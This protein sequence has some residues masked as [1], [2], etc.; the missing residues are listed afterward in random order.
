MSSN[1]WHW[2]HP[3]WN[4]WTWPLWLQLGGAVI[5]LV[6]WAA[7]R[8]IHL[9]A[10]L[11][12]K[13]RLYRSKT[14]TVPLLEEGLPGV[15]IFKPL[16]PGSDSNLV[17][18][19]DT[20][21]NLDYPKYEIL[22]CIQDPS[23]TNLGFFVES[24]QE[25]YPLVETKVFYGGETIG[26]NPKINNMHPA[27]QASK[28]ELI[29]ISDSGIRMNEDTLTDMVAHMTNS[30]GLVHQMPYICDKSGIAASLEK[31]YFGTSH[32][33]AY[34]AANLLGINC[35]TGMSALMRKNL[36]VEAGGLKAFGS[37]LAED[38]FM[39]KAIMDQGYQIDI[40]SQP[41]QQNPG[42]SSIPNFHSRI[43][44]WTK[45]RYAMCPH[46]IVL[47]PLTE[48]VLLGILVAWSVH[49][50]FRWDPV[51][52]F[53][54]HIL[55]WFLMDWALILIVQNGS[56]PFSK[57]EFL[58]SWCIREFSVPCVLLSAHLYPAI[59]WR[60]N[61]FRLKWGGVAEKVEEIPLSKD[62]HGSGSRII[63]FR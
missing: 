25:K 1:L 17:Q 29:L 6:S 28:Y 2:H 55:I 41:A 49:F 26:V 10:L 39:A 11:R 52:F 42:S 34:L 32:A 45:L 62:D 46:F 21:F 31:V 13:W 8:L 58:V 40:S 18:N 54:L 24:L 36:L 63:V 60:N 43:I 23:D 44:R 57:F 33:R 14:T 37:Y 22:F 20:F 5:F 7:I 38:F 51:T 12:G 59:Y 27:F 61:K 47:E 4:Q 53:M 16:C 30:V 19:L 56:L 9:L 3:P 15:S 50:L 48:C 35:A